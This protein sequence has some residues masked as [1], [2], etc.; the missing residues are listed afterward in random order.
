MLEV[1][2]P[3]TSIV[4]AHTQMFRTLHKCSYHVEILERKPVSL[5]FDNLENLPALSVVAQVVLL[6]EQPTLTRLYAPSLR[7]RT[8]RPFSRKTGGPVMNGVSV[9][10]FIPS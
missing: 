7:T 10:A 8:V 1:C 2:F 5:I 4:S 9:F 3:V 6:F